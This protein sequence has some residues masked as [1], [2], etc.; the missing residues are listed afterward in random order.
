VLKCGLIVVKI[1]RYPQFWVGNGSF[2]EKGYSPCGMGFSTLYKKK[3]FNRAYAFDYIEIFYNWERRHSHL[4]GG[5]PES[6][7]AASN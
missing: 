6:F 3:E 5:S 7:E 4:G 2:M 1:A